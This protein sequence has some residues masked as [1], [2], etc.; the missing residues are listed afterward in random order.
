MKY[1][2][3]GFQKTPG[4]NGVS[5]DGRAYSMPEGMIFECIRESKDPTFKGYITKQ[6]KINSDSP[7][8]P[9]IQNSDLINFIG[10]ALEY[11]VQLNGKYESIIDFDFIKEKLNFSLHK[12]NDNK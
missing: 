8:W 10:Q 12:T 9:V 7:F 11:E 1:L 2:I 5:K 6:V 4:K 3:V